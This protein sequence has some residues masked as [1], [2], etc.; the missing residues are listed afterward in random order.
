MSMND[1]AVAEV[2]DFKSMRTGVDRRK[3]PTPMFSRYTLFGGRRAGERRADLP[4]EGMYVDQYDSTM[5][6][7]VLGIAIFNFFDCFFTL[8]QLGRGATELNPFVN[9]LIEKSPYLFIFAKSLGIGIILC[10]LCL[11]RNFRLAR[12]TMVFAFV[13]YLALFLYHL[14][15]YTF[16]F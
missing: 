5:L 14:V 2:K 10:F 12:G 7:M 8:L 11:H 6:L 13:L 1:M 3:R 9:A 15:I 4:K 16:Q